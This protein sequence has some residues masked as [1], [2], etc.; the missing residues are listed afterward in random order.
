MFAALAVGAPLGTML[1]NSGGFGLVAI[2]ASA[3]PLAT[4]V[5]IAP[6]EGAAPALKGAQPVLFVLRRIWVPGFGA[7]LSSVGFG[8]IAAFGSLLFLDHHWTPVWLAFSAYAVAL[9]VARMI[10]GQLPDRIGGARVALA[11]VMVEV[12]GLVI[13]WLA[14]TGWM[15]AIGA[16]LTGFGYSLVFPA[17]GVEAVRRAPPESRGVA[18]GA[19]TACLDIALGVSGPVLG[20]LATRTGLSFVFLVSAVVVLG[21]AAVSLLLLR[22]AAPRCRCD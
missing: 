8:A 20:A 7:A 6:L 22:P 16:A 9:I 15:A 3:A 14:A 10:F 19:Y 21:T 11:F 13:M 12:L 18:M 2:A 17:L 5:L 1:Y 4:L